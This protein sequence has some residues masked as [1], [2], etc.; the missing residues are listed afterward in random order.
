[1]FLSR[2]LPEFSTALAAVKSR[3]IS[4]ESLPSSRTRALAEHSRN[5]PA[6]GS[7]R[8]ARPPRV[9]IRPREVMLDEPSCRSSISSDA[10]VLV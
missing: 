8:N 1:M 6:P 4:S 9:P 7:Q 10:I 3:R 5:T 2:G